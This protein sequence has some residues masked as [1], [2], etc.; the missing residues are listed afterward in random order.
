MKL[1]NERTSDWKSG[2]DFGLRWALLAACLCQLAY[3][4]CH[5]AVDCPD[6]NGVIRYRCEDSAY[7][8]GNGECCLLDNGFNIFTLWYF[9]A[10]IGLG[11]VICIAASRVFCKS[12]R[13]SQVQVQDISKAAN[14]LQVGDV[15][16]PRPHLQPQPQPLQQTQPQQVVVV[17]VVYNQP[18]IRVPQEGAFNVSGSVLPSGAMTTAMHPGINQPQGRRRVMMMN[19]RPPPGLV[20][21]APALPG[22]FV[23]P[24]GPGYH[25]PSLYG[26]LPPGYV[27]P[28]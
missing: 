27:P 22:E 11:L 10:S 7:C 5:A 2:V 28:N 1:T 13:H 8:C 26:P 12:K 9:W 3:K 6:Q 18:A 17:P 15:P 24:F 25:Q 14:H 19:G 23:R 21:P 16:R 4:G 20:Q